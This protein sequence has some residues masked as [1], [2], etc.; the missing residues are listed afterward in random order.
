M[1]LTLIILTIVAAVLLIL[2]ILAQ[3]SKG[4]LGGSFGGS[5]SSQ[6]MG[7]KKTSDIL[8]KLTWGFAGAILVFC[9]SATIIKKNEVN[10]GT[11]QQV[12]KQVEAAEDALSTPALDAGGLDE[13]PVES[14]PADN[15]TEE[16][17]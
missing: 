5:G 6:M 11:E 7:V 16:T 17:K 8:E 1:Y 9:V 2:F 4:G 13:A 14:A 15:E 12:N 3:N 10:T